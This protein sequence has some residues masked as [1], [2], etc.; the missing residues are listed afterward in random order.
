[1]VHSLVKARV[2]YHNEHYEEVASLCQETIPFY[3]AASGVIGLTKVHKEVLVGTLLG[4]GYM[5]QKNIR[6][7][8]I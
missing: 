2:F 8:L 4:D 5:R 1:M 3:I 6:I 7:I